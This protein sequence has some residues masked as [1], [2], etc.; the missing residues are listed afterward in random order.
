M[1]DW[2]KLLQQAEAKASAALEVDSVRLLAVDDTVGILVGVP[3]G[4]VAVYTGADAAAEGE[5]GPTGG[6]VP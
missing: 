2:K 1:K 3:H 6:P 5:L 4:K